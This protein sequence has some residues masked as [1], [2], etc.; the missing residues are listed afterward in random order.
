MTELFKAETG[1]DILFVPYKGAAQALTDLLA[2][3]TQVTLLATVV[4]LT[5]VKDGKLRAL[6]VTSAARLAEF[7]GV[8]TMQESGFTDF[9]PGSW[10]AVVAPVNTPPEIV[11]RLNAAI[12]ES[13]RSPELKAGFARLRA[14]ANIGT[15]QDLADMIARE[16]RNWSA[17]VKSLGLKVE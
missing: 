12:N 17:V 11:A 4:M 9:P 2:G 7:P 5:P 8:P 3:Q 1:S 10:Q 15:P 13:L 16:N 14:E 6:A